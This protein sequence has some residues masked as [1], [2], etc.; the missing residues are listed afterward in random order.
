MKKILKWTLKKKGLRV[1]T[2]VMRQRT[3][4]DRLLNTIMESLCY[5]EEGQFLDCWPVRVTKNYRPWNNVHSHTHFKDL[6]LIKITPFYE[7]LQWRLKRIDTILGQMSK[8]IN[9]NIILTWWGNNNLREIHLLYESSICSF[10]V[11]N[12]HILHIQRKMAI[13]ATLYLFL[14]TFYTN[15]KLATAF[16]P[17]CYGMEI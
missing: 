1:W 2:G 4:D 15:L 11:L 7:Q 6:T 5:T 17:R 9:R 13:W 3:S 16:H 12:G 10:V 8:R 14:S